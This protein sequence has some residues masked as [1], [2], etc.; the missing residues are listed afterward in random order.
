[1]ANTS[2]TFSGLV[3][4]YPCDDLTTTDTSGN[5]NTG[6]LAGSGTTL[7]AGLINNKLTFNGSGYITFTSVALLGLQFSTSEISV[8]CWVKT[9]QTGATILS[10]RNSSN[11]Q[12]TFDFVIGANPLGGSNNGR[13]SIGIR[14]DGGAGGASLSGTTAI[15]DGNWHHVAVT[16]NSSQN[17]KLYVDGISVGSQGSALTTSLT[18]DVAG[19][20]IGY[21]R[22]NGTGFLVGDL[23]DLQI[24][25]RALTPTEITSILSGGAPA[26]T[27]SAVRG[28]FALTGIAA[29]IRQSAYVMPVTVAPFAFGVT[30]ASMLY[31]AI[32]QQTTSGT[33]TFTGIASGSIPGRVLGAAPTA[34]ILTGLPAGVFHT[35]APALLANIGA[36]TLTGN[37]TGLLSAHL[38]ST[39]V[40]VFSLTG[41]QLGISTIVAEPT[42]FMWSYHAAIL[43]VGIPKMQIPPMVLNMGR[44]VWMRPG[45]RC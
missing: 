4:H 33:F 5:N 6:I 41:H 12:A 14:D 30:A 20:A 27:L 37:V 28:A 44:K 13:T 11:I 24:Y 31:G 23:D 36:F 26:Y 8:S 15:N 29:G 32:L 22:R 9:T 45:Q 38:M 10:L 2:V 43:G 3:L 18:P 16:L 34:F 42:L 35:G 19:S 7:S 1:M 25:N 40:G 39:D 21:E 17:L